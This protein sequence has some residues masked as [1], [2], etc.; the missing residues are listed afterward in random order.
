[1]KFESVH[2]Y[3]I[4]YI[5]SVLFSAGNENLTPTSCCDRSVK[6]YNHVYIH[7]YILLKFYNSFILHL[8]IE[9]YGVE[10][11]VEQIEGCHNNFYLSTSYKFLTTIASYETLYLKF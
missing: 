5:P 3:R 2:I 8:E 4:F 7:F 9:I 1:L 6:Q 11:I 10:H